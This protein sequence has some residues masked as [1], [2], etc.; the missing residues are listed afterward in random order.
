M[1]GVFSHKDGSGYDDFP[2]EHYQFPTRYL[3]RVEEMVGDWI[4]YYQP[5][6]GKGDRVFKAVAQVERIE[7]NGKGLHLARIATG[8][9]LPF[10]RRVDWMEGGRLLESHLRQ[11]DGSLNRGR[12]QWAVRPL[13]ETD[14]ARIV[15]LGLSDEPSLLPRTDPEDQLPAPGRA[16]PGVADSQETFAGL[17]PPRDHVLTSRAVR[18]RVF[19]RAVLAAYAETCA[20][21]G[22]R[23]ING[24]GRAEVEAAHIR[25]VSNGG[26]DVVRNGMALS[27]TIH[28][29]FDRGLLSLSD[30][31]DILVSRQVND[32][33]RVEA[34]LRANGKARV[35]DDPALRPHPRYLAWHRRERFKA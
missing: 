12:V 4:V 24:K 8:S 14:F 25:P 5:G 31:Y 13:A 27:G 2:E 21:S 32:P 19:R 15:D 18:D 6:K 35:P 28:W 22:M 16:I 29:M 30:H 1:K 10:D 17:A 9:Y 23:F 3:K 34:M 20:I 33:D 26:P 7:P 11:E